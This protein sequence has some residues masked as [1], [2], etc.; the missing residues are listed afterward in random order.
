[1]AAETFH[2]KIL[3]RWQELSIAQVQPSKI[4]M[5]WISAYI[6][7]KHTECVSNSKPTTYKRKLKFYKGVSMAFYCYYNQWNT[8][9]WVEYQENRRSPGKRRT[10]RAHLARLRA[11]KA[12]IDNTRLSVIIRK[13]AGVFLIVSIVFA[14]MTLAWRGAPNNHCIA[15]YNILIHKLVHGAKYNVIHVRM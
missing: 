12:H 5:G 15:T 6:D 4:G 9:A 8:Q 3:A 7:T 10:W 11:F 2:S 14:S 1:M 13:M